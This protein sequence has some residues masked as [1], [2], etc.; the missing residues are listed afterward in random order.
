MWGSKVSLGFTTDKNKMW[1][2]VHHKYDK[3][4]EHM[5]VPSP[6]IYKK[7]PRF[8]KQILKLSYYVAPLMKVLV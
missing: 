6:R 3:E 1:I 8:I 2:I 5:R 7:R 4:T